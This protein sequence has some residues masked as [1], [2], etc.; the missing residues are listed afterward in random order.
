MLFERRH[1]ARDFKL[2]LAHFY[3]EQVELSLLREHV[4]DKI[5]N[6]PALVEYVTQIQN[7]ISQAITCLVDG[8]NY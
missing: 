5:S 3:K 1:T 8:K 4:V 2:N 6:Q 7:G